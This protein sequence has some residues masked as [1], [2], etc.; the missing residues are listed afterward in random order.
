MK[1]MPRVDKYMTPMPH[2]INSD[3]NISVAEKMMRDNG[4]RHLPVRNAAHLVGVI[5][6][7]DIKLARSFSQ[8]DKLLVEEAMT[9]DPYTVRPHAPLDEVVMEMA[10]RK[11]GCAVVKQENDTIVGIFT[12]SDG[13][14]ALADVLENNFKKSER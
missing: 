12:A 8:S 3:V 9:A 6:E 4:F 2:T 14:R 13:L 5:T 10:E 1:Q 11:L 7:R